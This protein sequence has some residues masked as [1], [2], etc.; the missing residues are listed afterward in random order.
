MSLEDLRNMGLLRETAGDM[1]DGRVKVW[2]LAAALVL[3]AAGCAMMVIGDGNAMTVWGMIL[4]LAG[5]FAL[6]AANLRGVMKGRV[7]E[8]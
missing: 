2:Q 6:I 5:F 4:F 3:V 8:D 7:R 1:P